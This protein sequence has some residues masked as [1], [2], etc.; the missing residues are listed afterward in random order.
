ME[1]KHMFKV[2]VDIFPKTISGTNKCHKY[3]FGRYDTK[4]EAQKT[5][6][7]INELGKLGNASIEKE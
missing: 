7:A 4:K 5:V 2:V 3:I 6:D 1:E